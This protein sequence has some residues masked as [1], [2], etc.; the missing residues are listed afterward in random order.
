MGAT[1][2]I[3]GGGAVALGLTLVA[4]VR[5]R[6]REM[7]MLRTIGFTGH[8]LARSVTWRAADAERER[9]GGP[10]WHSLSVG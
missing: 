5:R 3:L 7:A 1:P 9:C 6:R 4:S 2:A 10:R 8:R